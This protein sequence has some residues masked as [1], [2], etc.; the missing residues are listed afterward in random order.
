M[1]T[2][3]EQQ[4]VERVGWLIRA[5]PY[6]A[7][8]DYDSYEFRLTNDHWVGVHSGPVI[9]VI[10][11][12]LGIDLTRPKGYASVEEA[13]KHAEFL[14]RESLSN[15]LMYAERTVADMRQ[16]LSDFPAHPDTEASS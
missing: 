1:A 7:G 14:Y 4:Q 3:S 8:R 10:Q 13:M 15:K 16:A 12:P 5:E 11:C 9:K 6:R 2:T